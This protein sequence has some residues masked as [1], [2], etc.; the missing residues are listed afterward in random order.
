MSGRPVAAIV[1][2]APAPSQDTG[3]FTPVGLM[4]EAAAE[5]IRDSGVAKSRIDG[6][7][8][9]SSYYYLPTMTLGEYLQISPRFSDTT[10]IG[11]CSFV[12]HLR[13]AA[14]A[15]D[16]GSCDYALIAHS[17][18]QRSDG[19]SRVFSASESLA[20]EAPYDPLWPIT[21]YALIA[22]R[23]MHEYGTT[24]EHLAEVAVA[25]RQWAVLNPDAA[26]SEQLTI[27]DVLSSPMI[28]TPL[29]RYDCCLVSDGAG[30]LVVTSPERARD[31]HESPIYV[32]GAAE[33]HGAR[34]VSQLPSFVSSPATVTGPG[35][36]AQ[37]GVELSDVDTFQVY[38]AFTITTLQILEDL[39][40]CPK[41][42]AGP[43]VSDGRLRPGGGL[44]VNTSGGGLS[45]RHP[46]M[47]GMTL[48]LEAATQLRHRG[49]PRQVPDAQLTLVHG[50]GGVQMSGATAVLAGPS[51]SW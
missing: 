22:S 34:S 30:A 23:H 6:L 51:W 38:D 14:F 5:A 49:G 44:P 41:G 10:T 12:A 18:T 27:D 19:R 48:L 31:E 17:S 40:L 7:L 29:H 20:Y 28:S 37:A 43:F 4:A 46:G 21:G 47:L 1:G 13:H 3:H 36:L 50:L 26:V 8:S 16:A 33:G 9:A 39:G 25:A 32:L 42:E 11:G 35:A 2:A 24:S 45:Y 15:I